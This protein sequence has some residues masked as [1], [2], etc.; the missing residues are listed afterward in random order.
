MSDAADTLLREMLEGDLAT[1]A[2]QIHPAVGSSI[3]VSGQ[4]V[5]RATGIVAS[6]L[7]GIFA[8]E[9]ATRIHHLTG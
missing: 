9:H 2:V 4:G 1:V 5:V 7:T 8:Q 3:T 6:T